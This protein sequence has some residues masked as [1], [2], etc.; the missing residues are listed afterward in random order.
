M[1]WGDVQSLKCLP[2]RH[3]TLNWIPGPIPALRRQ[4]DLVAAR[5]ASL[6]YL[7]SPGQ[8]ETLSGKKR[9][10]RGT[11]EQL[12]TA[13]SVACRHR[14]TQIYRQ[15]D[16]CTHVCT[17]TYTCTLTCM[18]V[19]T[20]THIYPHTSIPAHTHIHAHTPSLHKRRTIAEGVTLRKSGTDEWNSQTWPQGRRARQ[21]ASRR[22]RP[23]PRG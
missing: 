5:L 8:G 4:V 17:S 15:P 13:C 19:H 6:A 21:R 14:H 16:T 7:V 9:K 18:L 1:G 11:E 3:E 2:C 22:P 12:P 10:S 23:E 20:H